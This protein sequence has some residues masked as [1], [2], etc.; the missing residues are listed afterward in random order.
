MI[1]MLIIEDEADIMRGLIS[2][3]KDKYNVTLKTT[4]SDALAELR[5]NHEQYDLVILDL[6]LPRG[7]PKNKA[8]EV[9]EIRPEEVGEFV[10]ERMGKIC[11][12]MATIVL[13]GFRSNLNGMRDA[14]NVELMTKPA[15]EAELEEVIAKVLKKAGGK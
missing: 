3:L 7:I 13:T 15:I 6:M 1:K 12:N 2:S 9:P 4:G 5:K 8:D 11:P 10:F 14:P